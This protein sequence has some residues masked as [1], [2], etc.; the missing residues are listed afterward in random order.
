MNYKSVEIMFISIIV[1]MKIIAEHYR[2]EQFLQNWVVPLRNLE[3]NLY[4]G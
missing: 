4:S 2:I 1:I 3:K